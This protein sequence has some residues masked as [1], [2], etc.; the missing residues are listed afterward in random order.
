MIKD[1]D[2]WL[3]S[4][5]NYLVGVALYEKY[6]DNSTLKTLFRS[7]CNSWLTGKLLTSIKDLR[8]KAAVLVPVREPRTV[9]KE[10]IR[11]SKNE[12]DQIIEDLVKEKGALYKEAANLHPF[13]HLM[14]KEELQKAAPRI[15]QN[16]KRINRIWQIIDNHEVTG[17]VP[18]NLTGKLTLKEFVGKIR[19][20]PTYVTKLK[21]KLENMEDGNEKTQVSKDLAVYEAEISRLNKI[22][23]NDSTIIIQS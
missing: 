13:L 22:M 11:V 20:L 1:L 14:S 12:S 7:G 23:E 19:N 18:V 21:K 9:K 8:D 10:T 3:K 4:G 2:D 6:G 17:A 5:R 15:L 16:F